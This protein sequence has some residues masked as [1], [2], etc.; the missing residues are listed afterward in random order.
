MRFRHTTLLGTCDNPTQHV[1]FFDLMPEQLFNTILMEVIEL[2][3]PDSFLT[4]T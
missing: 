4:P 2:F 1:N 3:G